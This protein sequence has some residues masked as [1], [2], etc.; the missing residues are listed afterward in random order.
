M[1]IL[2]AH[3]LVVIG[4]VRLVLLE[5]ISVQVAVAID[6]VQALLGHVAVR[7]EQRHITG[8]AIGLRKHDQVEDSRV[9]GCVE[10]RE[11]DG[12]KMRQLTEADLMQDLAR[13]RLA[14]IIAF[15]RLIGR[16]L[17]ECAT[18]E[19]RGDGHV[20]IGNGQAIASKERHEPGHASGR[21]PGFIRDI[22]VVDAQ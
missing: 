20:L 15:G 13:L 3:I 2:P 19:A 10:R 9:G 6:P 1:S 17:T 4:R 22:H 12:A 16:E 8:P 7:C 14:P 11:G 5:T 21:H 18:R